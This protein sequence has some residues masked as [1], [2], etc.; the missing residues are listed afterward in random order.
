MGEDPRFRTDLFRGAADDYDRYRLRYPAGLLDD[1]RRHADLGPDAQVLD[2]AC[3]TGQVA[4]AIAPDVGEVHAVDQEPDM[5]AVG[6][7]AAERAGITN[8]RWRVGTAE[9]VDL[10]GPY[11]LVT[12]GNAFHRLNRQ[13]VADRLVPHLTDRGAIALLWTGM[14]SEG[15]APWQRVLREAIEEWLRRPGLDD[16]LPADWEEP[17]ERVPH[18]EVLRRA[19]LEDVETIETHVDHVWTI[20]TLIGFQHGTSLL[21]RA[22]LGPRADAFAKDLRERLVACDPSGT[23]PQ[24]IS[25]AAEV[26]RR[27]T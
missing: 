9:D 4:L 6:Q 26:G 19:G 25:Y 8:V 13:H 15:D 14:P 27:A 11:G 10:D 22:A 24:T 5:I 2:L 23:F 12:I 16:R 18:E 21:N 20:E 3:G 1:V 17:I 7:R